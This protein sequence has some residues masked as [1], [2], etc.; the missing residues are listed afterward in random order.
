MFYVLHIFP[1]R[2]CV[3]DH[4]IEKGLR[5]EDTEDRLTGDWPGEDYI[6]E[7]KEVGNGLLQGGGGKSVGR[8]SWQRVVRE[9][10]VV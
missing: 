4:Y 9:I 6:I 5:K 3:L 2:I 1:S 7:K 10:R 8:E